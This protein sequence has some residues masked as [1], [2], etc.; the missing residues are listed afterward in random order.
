MSDPTYCKIQNDT[1]TLPMRQQFFMLLALLLSWLFFCFIP[2]SELGEWRKYQDH[3]SKKCITI[4]SWWY[5]KMFTYQILKLDIIKTISLRAATSQN[6]VAFPVKPIRMSGWSSPCKP[7]RMFSAPFSPAR[8]YR[9][10][11]LY[12]LYQI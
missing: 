5:L 10:I 8:L 7:V 12:M 11:C 1:T 3:M 2:E 4:F 9:V 6:P